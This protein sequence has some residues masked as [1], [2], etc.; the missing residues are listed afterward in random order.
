MIGDNPGTVN[1]VTKSFFGE[2]L[3]GEMKRRPLPRCVTWCGTPTATA[4]LNRP[5]IGTTASPNE[6]GDY[7]QMRGFVN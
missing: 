5:M 4:R 3:N 7:E 2:K 6:L 1:Q